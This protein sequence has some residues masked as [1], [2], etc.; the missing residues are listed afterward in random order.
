MLAVHRPA[1]PVFGPFKERSD[2]TYRHRVLASVPSSS[3]EQGIWVPKSL[4]T[5]SVDGVT[6]QISRTLPYPPLQGHVL[7]GR[8][9]VHKYEFETK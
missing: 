8:C 7:Q 2:Q 1:G 9:P 3:T 6:Q 5:Y 4:H